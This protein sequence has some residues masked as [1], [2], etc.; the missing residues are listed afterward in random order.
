MVEQA[1]TNEGSDVVAHG[2]GQND[3]KVT[4]G[5]KTFKK[6]D[7]SKGGNDNKDMKGSSTC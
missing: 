2:E 5:N 1:P 6:K 7:F 3:K 4:S